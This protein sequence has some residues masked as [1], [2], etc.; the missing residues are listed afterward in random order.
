MPQHR[1]VNNQLSISTLARTGACAPIF[2]LE[3]G[4]AACT[5]FGTITCAF[6]PRRCDAI[7][8]RALVGCTREQISSKY[9]QVHAQK[10]MAWLQRS[11]Y[12]VFFIFLSNQTALTTIAKSIPMSIEHAQH[13][14]VIFENDEL[15]ERYSLKAADVFHE[16]P[17]SF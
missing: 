17:Q 16:L 4:I 13:P 8:A 9:V 1:L 11:V 3:T 6:C 12:F 7:V 2:Q 10:G 14:V 5:N 15:L